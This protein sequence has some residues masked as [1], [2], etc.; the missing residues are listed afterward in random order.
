[1]QKILLILNVQIGTR[2]ASGVLFS[3]TVLNMDEEKGGNIN[4]GIL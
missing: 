1:M 2:P 4:G 3:N